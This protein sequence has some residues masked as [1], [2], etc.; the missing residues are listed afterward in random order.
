MNTIFFHFIETITI[1]FKIY[2]VLYIQN[3]SNKL[4]INFR[5]LFILQIEILSPLMIG[6]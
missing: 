4:M 6:D 1:N 5:I 3:L 2:L